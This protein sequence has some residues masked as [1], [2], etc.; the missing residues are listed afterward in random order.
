MCKSVING[1]KVC[2]EQ[3]DEVI[4]G[5]EQDRRAEVKC[6]V[7]VTADLPA[8][9]RTLRHLLSLFTHRNGNINR[10]LMVFSAKMW[11][12]AAAGLQRVN[13]TNNGQD[14]DVQPPA[15]PTR[16]LTSSR[17]RTRM[18]S[19]LHVLLHMNSINYIILTL[20]FQYCWHFH[21][22]TIRPK[23]CV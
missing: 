8:A 3:D 1:V 19:N 20:V 18:C 4:W 21:I 23:V 10:C 14:P 5:V 12:C 16:A 22:C 6:S 7:C 9:Y 17:R 2:K 13:N 11:C 15:L